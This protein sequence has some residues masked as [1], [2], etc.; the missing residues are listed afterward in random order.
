LL[1]S[2]SLSSTLAPPLDFITAGEEEL[3]CLDFL[4][5]VLAPAKDFFTPPPP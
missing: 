1:L 3:H 2:C 4:D 5:V